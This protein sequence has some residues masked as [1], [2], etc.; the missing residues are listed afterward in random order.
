MM[1][2]Q[3][4]E[5][6]LQTIQGNDPDKQR[7]NNIRSKIRNYFK[8]RECTCLVRPLNEESKLANIENQ[9]WDELRPEFR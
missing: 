2:S 5:Y 6:A 4:L 3:Y 8:A 9:R 7:K 1:Y